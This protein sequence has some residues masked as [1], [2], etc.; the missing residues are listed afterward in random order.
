[1]RARTVTRTL[2]DCLI[3]L[4]LYALARVVTT[5]T[6]TVGFAFTDPVGFGDTADPKGF[7]ERSTAWDGQ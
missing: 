7:F 2:P 1:M 3:T 6:L 4:A 5:A